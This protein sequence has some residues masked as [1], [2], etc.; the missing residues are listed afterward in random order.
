MAKCKLK[1]VEHKYAIR[2][3]NPLYLMATHYKDVNHW[4]CQTLKNVGIEHIKDSIRG[5]DRIQKKLQS[6]F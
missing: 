1:L 2:P 4:S 6:E 3:R 5:R